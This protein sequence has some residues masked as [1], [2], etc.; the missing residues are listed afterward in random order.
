MPTYDLVI[1]NGTVIDG[2]GLTGYRADVGV[3]GGRIARIGRIAD[4][5]AQ[6]IDAEGHVV[7]PGFIDLHTHMDAQ[8]FWDPLGS[9]SCWHG[10]TTVLMGNCGFTLAPARR[11]DPSL[12][13]RN[14]ERAEAIERSAMESGIDWTWETFPEFLDAVDRRP[15]GINYA[16]LV[17][18]S[19]VR[20]WVM[21]EDAFRRVA[22]A[23]EVVAMEHIVADALAAGAWGFSTSRNW[24]HLT[25]DGDPVASRLASWDEVCSLVGVLGR[26]GTGIFEIA[27]EL[28]S[29]SRDVDERAEYH[30]RIQALAV[31]TG[32]PV[33]FGI[34]PAKPAS[35]DQLALLETTARAGGRAIGMS[36]SRGISI[37]LSFKTQLPFDGLPTWRPIR[38]L[39]L[40]EQREALQNEEIRRRLVDAAHNEP[41]GVAAGAEARRPSYD[42]ILVVD[43]PVP[44]Y[45]TVAQVAE[46]RGLDPVDAMIEL[47]LETDFDQLFMQPTSR[48]AQDDLLDVM[49]HPYTVMTFSDSGAHVSQIMDS[50]I[51][52]HLLAYWVR[53]RQAF[54]LEEA[55]RMI[56]LAPAVAGGFTDRGLL[57]EG[58]VAD[59][60]VFDPQRVGP[61]LPVVANDLPAGAQRLKQTSVG[62]LATVVAGE[63]VIAVGEHTGMLPGQLVRSV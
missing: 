52:T 60:N 11:D 25:P 9:C 47:A 17:G 39:P 20:T 18:H 36:H 24:A 58:M 8:V 30:D 48:F 51:H 13:I 57:R 26:T 45:A 44:P 15:K 54:T 42:N 5:A 33:L 63:V 10:V 62:F 35:D 22:S 7:T 31:S 46:Q 23:D 61:T 6:Q 38:S 49:K 12:V 29:F 59:L 21:G 34:V 55:V 40:V 32:V 27:P 28:A 4:R 56:T 14:I 1:R 3:R 37:M 16:A 43:S 50:S 19:A 2:S 41:Y 53:D